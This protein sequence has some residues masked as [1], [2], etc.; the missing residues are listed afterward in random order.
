MIPEVD[1][2]DILISIGTKGTP[3]ESFWPTS[4][5]NAIFSYAPWF[6]RKLRHEVSKMTF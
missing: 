6:P 4:F 3:F 5:A 1:E 2:K